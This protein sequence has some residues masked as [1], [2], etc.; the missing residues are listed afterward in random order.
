MKDALE[1]TEEQDPDT[2]QV[3]L[4]WVN[5]TRGIQGCVLFDGKVYWLTRIDPVT[6]RVFNVSL[7]Q[8]EW[9]K[10]NKEMDERRGKK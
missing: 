4:S 6:G 10:R 5:D 7:T 2:R 3:K 9:N 8:D 1:V